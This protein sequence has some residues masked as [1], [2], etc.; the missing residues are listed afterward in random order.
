MTTN[1]P[2]FAEGLPRDMFKGAILVSGIFDLEPL[3]STSNND[4]LRLDQA[5]AF[6]QSPMN[7]AAATVAP[8]LI[9]YGD[10]ETDEFKWQ[11]NRYAAACGSSNATITRQI[12]PG[13]H[14]GVINE[15]SDERRGFHRSA[16]QFI[17]ALSTE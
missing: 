2:S 5:E 8:Q 16:L 17:A 1:W 4:Q 10:D 12:V 14:F 3:L 7:H 6:S 11:S 15:L 13:H 9:A